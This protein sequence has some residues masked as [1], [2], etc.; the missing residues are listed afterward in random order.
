MAFTVKFCKTGYTDALR[1]NK[2]EIQSIFTPFI[3]IDRSRY[4]ELR[5]KSSSLNIDPVKARLSK[6]MFSDFRCAIGF[7]LFHSRSY[8]PAYRF[9]VNEYLNDEWLSTV[10]WHKK[11]HRDHVI[12]QPM[13]LYVGIS[14]LFG[15]DLSKDEKKPTLLFKDKSLL[16]HCLDAV[17][18][19]RCDYLKKYFKD[20]GGSDLYLDDSPISRLLW[21]NLF[22]ESF[23]LATLFHDIGY[24]WLFLNNIDKKLGTHFPREDLSQKNAEWITQNYGKRLLFYPFYGYEK[25]DPSTPPQ[26]KKLKKIE[27]LVDDSLR[28]T[29]G[30]SGSIALLYL[31]DILRKDQHEIHNFPER[32]FCI[33]WAAMAV[34][35]HD[36]A[37]IYSK[38]DKNYQLHVEHPQLRVSI[39]K[40]PLSFILALTDQIQDF[41]RPNSTFFCSEDNDDES[42]VTY[43]SN[44]KSVTLDLTN[45]GQ[46]N[47]I[48]SYDDAAIY[49][50]NKTQFLPEN[51]KLFFDP[52]RGYID[53]K[54]LGIKN[55][56]LVAQ[57][58]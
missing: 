20:M 25:L 8:F 30:I 38:L 6:K 33:E 40:D 13:S 31:N 34:M 10:D 52:D 9:F 12:H 5:I 7:T 19:S 11:F 3:Q 24:P 37:K 14:L 21:K 53:Y 49:L 47:I 15:L 46:L 54:D 22:L 36:M 50:K 41:G 57:Q 32:R 26:N 55:I 51:A 4:N 58:D 45:T 28:E 35:M 16:D 18:S 27:S 43:S 44:C 42:T 17:H 2:L 1:K 56:E 29:H 39:D 23:Y 48:Y